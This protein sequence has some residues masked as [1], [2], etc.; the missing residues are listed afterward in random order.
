[1]NRFLKMNRFFKSCLLASAGLVILAT[2][3]SF[4]TPGRAFAQ[5]VG[6]DCV[7]ICDT[8]SNPLHVIVKGI[9]RIKGEVT[10]NNENAIATTV[11]GPV[12]VTTSPRERVYVRGLVAS[13]S[14]TFHIAK[15]IHIG[16]G[17]FSGLLSLPIPAGK[18]L[19]IKSAVGYADMPRGPVNINELLGGQPDAYATQIPLV[20]IKTTA[21]GNTFAH[22]LSSNL[23][24]PLG[25]D[26]GGLPN[27]F[28]WNIGGG[29]LHIF[30]DPG[31]EITLSFER[32]SDQDFSEGVAILKLTISGY[33]IDI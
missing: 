29:E 12:Q 15:T 27:K 19:V 7:R 8:A 33:Y 23:V 9:T 20:L 14:D 31:S 25:Y 18:L 16:S 32:P 4:T 17:Q 13:S 6:E 1:M 2:T 3:L 30:A 10:I 28:R 11:T 22:P 21:D 24:G 26:Q 5:R